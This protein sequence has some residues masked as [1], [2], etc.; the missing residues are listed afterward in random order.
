MS[1]R[2]RDTEHSQSEIGRLIENLTSSVDTLSKVSLEQGCHNLGAQEDSTNSFSSENGILNGTR[3][4]AHGSLTTLGV[5]FQHEF[6]MA[7]KI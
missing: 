2:L 7:R 4:A 1:K 3:N 5:I 6:S